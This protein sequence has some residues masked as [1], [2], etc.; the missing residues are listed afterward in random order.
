MTSTRPHPSPQATPSATLEPGAAEKRWIRVKK[1][2]SA[3]VYSIFE[4]H[5]GVLGY[6]T[7]GHEPGIA[8]CDLELQIPKSRLEEAEHLLK[9]LGDLIYEL[10][11][12]PS[13]ES[14][15]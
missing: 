4:A 15:R 5:E 9:S 3:F 13:L 2:E 6:S 8:W 11:S 14:P 10:D 7:V 12:D 1:T